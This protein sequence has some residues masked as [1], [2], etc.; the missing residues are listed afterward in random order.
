MMV[1]IGS[2]QLIQFTLENI[3]AK[4]I[5]QNNSIS[6]P[7]GISL[8]IV[9]I[10]VWIIHWRIIK[11]QININSYEEL[12][13]IRTVFIYAILAISIAILTSSTIGILQVILGTKDSAWLQTATVLPYSI[14]W[15][16]H[17]MLS[18]PNES[19]SK[20]KNLVQRIYI[21]SACIFG[22]IMLSIGIGTILYSIL[23][24]GYDVIFNAPILF[25]N[26][27]TLLESIKEPVVSLI[28]GAL[29]WGSHWILFGFKD[30]KNRIRSLYL[31]LIT[32]CGGMIPITISSIAL[33]Y[34]LFQF[35]LQV[36]T[37]NDVIP[38]LPGSISSISVGLMLFA[39][40]YYVIKNVV[41]N[42]ST[43]VN[44]QNQLFTYLLSFIGIISFSVGISILIQSIL[45]S[46]ANSLSNTVFIDPETNLEIISLALSTT[47]VGGII[48]VYCYK[49]L[50]SF[51]RSN[52]EEYS[53]IRRIYLISILGL[54]TIITVILGTSGLFIIL[55]DIISSDIGINT[56]ESIS[57]PISVLISYLIVAPYHW[58]LY[59]KEPSDNKNTTYTP[60]N[61]KSIKK[62][63]VTILLPDNNQFFLG[64]LEDDLGYSIKI[65][66]WMDPK[67]ENVQLNLDTTKSIVESI[68]K[69]IGN[70]IIIIPEDGGVRIYSYE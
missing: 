62:K 45:A 30:T 57:I 37:E 7:L 6:V 39:Y 40:H 64:Q 5:I 27:E 47:I 8:L 68:E 22:L 25:D 9:G 29:L 52:S 26:N 44:S 21:Y 3:F 41:T 23:R 16:Y 17:W 61:I 50:Q 24:S 34:G 20:S 2:A 32:I 11:N 58:G 14:I 49:Q 70:E 12:S 55:R 51:S 42:E 36:N 69:S 66:K 54:F 10:P 60:S 59:K 43:Q 15:I 46:I 67:S 56:L 4:N 38:Q 65:F 28:S 48:W 33:L 31:Y 13:V 63:N 35:I 53:S 1:A 18:N 19:S